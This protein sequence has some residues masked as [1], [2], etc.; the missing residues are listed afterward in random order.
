PDGTFA[1]IGAGAAIDIAPEQT[2]VHV[3]IRASKDT[4]SAS[5]T[6]DQKAVLELSLP[7]GQVVL[8]AELD[9]P[10]LRGMWLGEATLTEVEQP[11]FHGGGFAPAAEM[12]ISLILEV[13]SAGPSRL[14]P[15]V[16]VTAARDG[17]NVTHRLE[18]AQ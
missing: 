10:G 2:E 14:V 6:A 18:A 11:S 5:P 4:I 8:G 15:C 7:Q 12:R 17:R 16:S 1:A 13:P 3:T 9:V